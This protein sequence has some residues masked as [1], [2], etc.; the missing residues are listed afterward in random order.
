M[1]TPHS[2]LTEGV[3][4]ISTV[5]DTLWTHAQQHPS[6]DF[7]TRLNVQTAFKQLQVGNK[8]NYRTY[9]LSSC[10]IIFNCCTVF[11]QTPQQMDQTYFTHIVTVSD[12]GYAHGSL[13]F[14]PTHSFVGRVW[15]A[16]DSTTGTLCGPITQIWHCCY[17]TFSQFGRCFKA[18]AHIMFVTLNVATYLV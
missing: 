15:E 13:G 1:R 16:Q 11:T 4:C 7:R 2:Y 6:N 14:R 12:L 10:Q 5:S 9:G 18:Q 8:V 17:I 3:F